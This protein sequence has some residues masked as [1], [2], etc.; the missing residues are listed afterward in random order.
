MFLFFCFSCNLKQGGNSHSYRQQYLLIST[1]NNSDHSNIKP[2]IRIGEIL[3]EPISGEKLFKATVYL[4]R[5]IPSSGYQL[6]ING[7]SN[8]KML[9]YGKPYYF[10]GEF[11]GEKSLTLRMRL[12]D[13][14]HIIT[15]LKKIANYSHEP[16]MNFKTESNLSGIVSKLAFNRIY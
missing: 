10:V 11:D 9:E 8:Y 2:G 1:P 7:E 13:Q 3:I 12:D 4:E 6:F 16:S 5:E 15:S 14:K